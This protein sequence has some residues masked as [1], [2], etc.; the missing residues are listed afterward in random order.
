MLNVGD[1]TALGVQE[2]KIASGECLHDQFAGN[3]N[4]VVLDFRLSPLTG[5][6][7][8][9]AAV[10]RHDCPIHDHGDESILVVRRVGLCKKLLEELWGHVCAPVGLIFPCADLLVEVY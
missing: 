6:A 7:N 4:L 2:N 3:W 8:A 10:T 9:E 5:L 1:L